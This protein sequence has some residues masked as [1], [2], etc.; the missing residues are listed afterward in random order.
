[1][2]QG[3]ANKYRQEAEV[4]RGQAATATTEPDREFWLRIAAKWRRMA[5]DGFPKQQ[6]QQPQPNEKPRA[7]N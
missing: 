3:R 6:A 7:P 1:M 5:D 4:C 2:D